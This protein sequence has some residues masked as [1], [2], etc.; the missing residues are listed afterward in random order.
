M[1]VDWALG[2]RV[3]TEGQQDPTVMGPAPGC[4]APSVFGGWA[5]LV[6][7]QKLLS[8]GRACSGV[9]LW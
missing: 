7:L 2:G 1:W 9:V 3:W 5:P 4:M 8:G 6:Q